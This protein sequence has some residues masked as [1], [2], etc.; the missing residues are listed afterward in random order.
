MESKALA[1]T[2]RTA[3]PECAPGD[4]DPP[5]LD[6]AI[7]D[8]SGSI[9]VRDP[10][11]FHAGRRAFCR[12]LI[13]AAAG[14]P[15]IGK[16]EIDLAAATCR[17][18][19][20][21]GAQSARAMA[22]AFSLAVGEAVAHTHS[23]RTLPWWRSERTWSTLTAYPVADDV[24]VWE[25]LERAPG[26]IKLRHSGAP[27]ERG[28]LTRLRDRAARLSGILSCGANT[29]THTLL[30]E[31]QPES[32]IV[33]RLLDTLE[34]ALRGTGATVGIDPEHALASPL[35]GPRR[36]LYLTLAG[37]AFVLTAVGL[38][39]PGV[40]TVPF[41]LATSYFLARSS[42]A[43]DERLRRTSFFGPILVEWETHEALGVASKAKLI[44]LTVTII[45][46]TVALAPLSLPILV[47]IVLISSMS[48]LGI[49]RMPQIEPAPTAPPALGQVLRVSLPR[50]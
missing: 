24:S 33:P 43:L 35:S 15:G 36:V 47:V 30:I 27:W 9:L 20:E 46:V 19:F 26:R 21:A 22:D 29:W 31:Y 4:A 39:I 34:L 40:P 38:L 48:V 3:P 32:P 37:G 16:A 44:G 28:R 1:E 50:P 23:A 2:S 12:R 13:E 45:L 7:D 41:L 17:I 8:R 18:Q 11:S 25:T 49:L 14:Q 6:I 5:C 42:P 10:R